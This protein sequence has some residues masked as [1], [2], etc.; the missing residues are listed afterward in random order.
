MHEYVRI[1]GI[2]NFSR[3]RLHWE[4]VSQ[5]LRI[6]N[7]PMILQLRCIRP[8]LRLQLQQPTRYNDRLRVKKIWTPQPHTTKITVISS[9]SWLLFVIVQHSHC[10]C[11]CAFMWCCMSVC[12]TNLL[13]NFFYLSLSSDPLILYLLH[14]SKQITVRVSVCS[15]GSQDCWLFV[16]NRSSNKVQNT[17]G[18]VD[19]QMLRC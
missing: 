3:H 18:A 10:L 9:F 12:S 17:I 2:E 11:V 8:R 13:C 5:S 4:L 16:C 14:K 6:A 19:R 7:E 15:C 1:L